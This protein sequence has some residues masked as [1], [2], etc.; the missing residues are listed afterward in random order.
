MH[1]PDPSLRRPFNPP[2]LDVPQNCYPLDACDDRLFSRRHNRLALL[3][4]L[5]HPW[6]LLSQHPWP[7][8]LLPPL[9]HAA[10]YPFHNPLTNLG[11]TAG[12]LLVPV[13]ALFANSLL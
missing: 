10:T 13:T 7:A 4:L 9:A 8:L 2:S 3:P 5:T 6:L 11:L 12:Y 1:L